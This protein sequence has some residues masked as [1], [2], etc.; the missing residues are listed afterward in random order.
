MKPI[1]AAFAAVFL[2][3]GCG[4]AATDTSTTTTTTTD[5]TV[6]LVDPNLADPNK[7]YLWDTGR[8]L[9]AN[10]FT[11]NSNTNTLVINNLPFDGVSSQGGAY[12]E[13]AILPNGAQIFANSPNAAE[14]QYLAV[15]YRSPNGTNSLVGAVG[16]SAYFGYGYGGAYAG[17]TSSSLPASRTAA[18]Q[19]KGAYAGVVVN[20]QDTTG[21]SNGVY[22]TDGLAT[23]NVDLQDIDTGGSIKGNV[24]GRHIYDE[25]GTLLGNLSPIVLNETTIDT[26]TNRTGDATATTYNL[27]TTAA[28]SGSWEGSFT[29]PNGQ[30]IVGFLVVE[31]ATPTADSTYDAVHAVKGR[32]VGAFIATQQP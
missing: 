18:Y 11:Y 24:T 27:D 29:G 17:R 12:Q 25:N 1:F 4:T 14:D 21:A 6:S 31:G 8:F 28:Q 7:R 19:Y 10:Q 23:I 20:R 22:A 13:S 2:V 26:T 9:M 32:E 3:A 16:T 15:I 5:G 30:E